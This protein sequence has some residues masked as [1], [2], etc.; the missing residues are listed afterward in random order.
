MSWDFEGDVTQNLPFAFGGPPLQGRLKE[1][2]AD[3][4]VDEML[5]YGPSGSGEHVFLKVFKRGLNTT[6]AARKLAK[7]AGVRQVAVGFAGLKDRQAEVVQYFTVQLPGKQDPDWGAMQEAG[8]EVLDAQRH[9]RKIRRGS[10]KGNR[11]ELCLRNIE[12]DHERAEAVLGRIAEQGVPNYFGPQRFGRMGSN[13]RRA[14]AW[15]RG[16][17]RKP[18]P[19]QRRMLVSAVRSHLF[20]QVLAERVQSRVWNQAL[21]GDVMMLDGA[22]GQFPFDEND[23]EIPGRLSTMAIHPSGPLAGG[24]GRALVADGEA[25]AI[26]Q[27]VMNGQTA[28]LWLEGLQ[29]NRVDADRRALRLKVDELDFSWLDKST[30]RLSFALTAG[31][32]ATCV[33][34]E[35]MVDLAD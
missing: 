19:E 14:D 27:R 1:S 25:L 22:G 2:E 17:G 35:L 11:F 30:L 12:G 15:F 28:A 20:N 29:G 6:D 10:L 21:A 33:V 31:G 13:L 3:F 5:G 32:Y 8:L 4:K 23:A 34:R 24:Q 26:E 18:K 9:D 7:F 16:E